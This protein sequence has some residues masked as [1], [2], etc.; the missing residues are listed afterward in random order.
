MISVVDLLLQ[1][2]QFNGHYQTELT[3]ARYDDLVQIMIEIEKRFDKQCELRV[4]TDGGGSIY[5]CGVWEA[6]EN[7]THVDQLIV[8]ITKIEYD[9]LGALL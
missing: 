5:L 4:C 3:K 9:S 6:G 8:S 1:A 2:E 7:G